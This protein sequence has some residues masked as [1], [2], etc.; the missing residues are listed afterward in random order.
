MNGQQQKPEEYIRVIKALGETPKIGPIP[1]DLILPWT[2]IAGIL[3][4]VCYIIF[5]LSLLYFFALSVWFCGAWWI[6]TGNKSY[7][8]TD[9]LIPLPGKAYYNANS[10]FVPATDRGSFKRMMAQK[11]RSTQRKTPNGKKEKIV[12]FQVESNLHAIMQIKIGSDNFTVLLKCDKN[13]ENWS[14]TIPFALSGIHH[15]LNSEEIDGQALA[16]SEALKDI[17]PG[18]SLTMMLGCR[19]KYHQR[20]KQLESRSQRK[21]LPLIELILESEA[22]RIEEITNKGFRQQWHQ[23][24]FATWTRNK[25]DLR[26]KSD[27]LG[28]TMNWLNNSMGKKVRQLTDT[29]ESYRRDIYIQLAKEIYNNGFLPW[30]LTLGTKAELDFRNLQPDEVWS[31]LLWYRFNRFDEKD[32]SKHKEPPPIPQ[33]ITVSETANGKR[34][35]YQVT[36]SNPY[37]PKDI[38]SI[39]IE[40]ENGRSSCPQHLSRRDL[41]A[42]NDELVAAMSLE[43][44]S[45]NQKNSQLGWS[46]RQEQLRWIWQRLSSLNVRDTE[47]WLE[48]SPGDKELAQDNLIKLSKQSTAA[49]LHA[50]ESGA[51]LDVGATLKQEEAIEAQKRLHQGAQPLFAALTILVYRQSEAELERA[52]NHLADAFGNAKLIRET[53][54]CWKL[55]TETLPINCQKQLQST[56]LFSERRPTLDT[57]SILGLLPITKPKNIERDG[58]EL[59]CRE[60]GYPIHINLF[61]NNERAIIT[62]KAGSGKSVLAAGAI[63]EALANGVRVVGMDMSNA[64]ESTFKLITQLLGNQGAYLNI[65]DNSFNLLQPPDLRRFTSRARSNRFRIWKNFTRKSLVSLAMGQ[66]DDAELIERVDSLI[67]KLINIFFEDDLIIERYNKAFDCGWQSKEWQNMPTLHDLL[68]FCSK[69]KLGLYDFGD[70][71]ARAIAQINNQLSAKLSDPNIGDAIGKPS[72]IPPNPVMKFFALSGLTNE[73]NAYIMALV[74]QAACLNTA[75]EHPKSLLVMDECSVLLGKR[76]FAEIVGER[77]AT[78]RKEG[79]S[80]LLIGQD[81]EAIVKCIASSQILRNTD[82]YFTGKTTSDAAKV[83]SSVLNFPNHLIRRNASESYRAN[84]QNFYSHWLVSR[85]DRFWD[86]LYFPSLV[87]LAAVANSVDE[88]AARNRI[89]VDFP[90]TQRG[91]IKALCKFAY[92]YN[93]FTTSGLP[94]SQ[95]GETKNYEKPKVFI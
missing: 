52:C 68:F 25:Q 30:K 49:N 59:I 42:V 61:K 57:T 24:A 43:N 85:D 36:L 90:P 29:D 8:F 9:R 23:Y 56:A 3:F 89:F 16:I 87:L 88:K 82:V 40:G 77:F 83:Y 14:A 66:I 80:V 20:L 71:E 31:E 13:E 94:L 44:I 7:E 48:I 19:S 69:E 86:C 63:V 74:A 10:L 73:N 55:W 1:A 15:E 81:L 34:M 75:L 33:L 5:G 95:I 50:F 41:V 53:Q 60:G 62:G 58:L 28:Q 51:G 18:E 46:S 6:L 64:G 54:V 65:L 39:L 4:I 38:T 72:N 79:Q 37:H 67:L 22:V 21:N 27:L 32:L 26:K 47:I 17:P 92:L 93:K 78:G 84:L 12:P 76:G 35:E 70:I 2:M 91:Q 11:T 45:L